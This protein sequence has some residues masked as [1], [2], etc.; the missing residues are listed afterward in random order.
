MAGKKE[1]LALMWEK[2][3]VRM[4]LEDPNK[5]VDNQ[6]LGCMQKETIPAEE[7]VEL[8]SAAFENF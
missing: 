3:N 6:Y 5:M 7:D 4:E 8:M 2:M 1:N